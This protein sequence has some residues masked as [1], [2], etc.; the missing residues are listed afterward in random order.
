[1][2]YSVECVYPQALLQSVSDSV[3]WAQKQQKLNIQT[4]KTV[5]SLRMCQ[6]WHCYFLMDHRLTSKCLSFPNKTSI[7]NVGYNTNI[8]KISPYN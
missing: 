4:K 2:T 1:M 5:I 8:I 3:G 7:E 6:L